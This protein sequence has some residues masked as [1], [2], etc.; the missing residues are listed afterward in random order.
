[1]TRKIIYCHSIIKWN[2]I[3][4]SVIPSQKRISFYGKTFPLG[5]PLSWEWLPLKIPTC[6]G[7][8]F[9]NTC[10]KQ[11]TTNKNRLLDIYQIIYNHIKKKQKTK[12]TTIW[13]STLNTY[14]VFIWLLS[15]LKN[16]QVSQLWLILRNNLI[17]R[18]LNLIYV[19]TLHFKHPRLLLFVYTLFR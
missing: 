17:S 4:R 9:T 13:L 5:F 10:C 18:S 3:L 8:T 11:R 1:M 14:C 16:W 12:N 2:L 19:K 6:V 15:N 7:M